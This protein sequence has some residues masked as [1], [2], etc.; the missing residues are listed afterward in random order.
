VTTGPQDRAAGRGRLRAGHAD[1]EQAIETLKSAFVDGRLTKSELAA[2]TGRALAA[3]TYADLGALTADIPP[4]PAAVPAPA[5]A[6]PAVPAHPPAPPIRRP[7]AR[8]AA[9]AGLCLL[10]AAAC[11]PIV[12]H[13]DPGGPG[14][15]PDHAWA[16]PFFLLFFLSAGA[17]VMILVLGVAASI[18]QRR[19]RRRLPPSP[20]P[21]GQAL[22][23]GRHDGSGQDPGPAGSRTEQTRT[24]LRAHQPRQPRRRIA[25]G[26]G[27]ALGGVRPT[28]GTA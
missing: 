21:G 17:G 23:G 2:R 16:K 15:N 12:G 4:E 26:A 18:Q 13:F 1:R 3:Q 8:A 28:P 20:G 10:I 25:A 22:D 6:A 7:L 24:D 27:Q 5:A 11:I 19:S 9:G 14:P